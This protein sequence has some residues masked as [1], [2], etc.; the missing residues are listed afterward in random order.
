MMPE[1]HMTRDDILVLA[2]QAGLDLPEAYQDELVA[3]Y[4]YMQQM[5]ARLTGSR[6]YSAEPAHIFD[7]TRF[8]PGDV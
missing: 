3:A 7:P 6:D 8:L 1:D 5:A 2:K 4:G